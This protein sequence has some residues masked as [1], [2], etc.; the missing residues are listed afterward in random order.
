MLLALALLAAMDSEGG[1]VTAAFTS[2]T[3]RELAESR[4]LQDTSTVRIS[5][6]KLD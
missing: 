2:S 6:L 3:A 4:H 5:S 1:L